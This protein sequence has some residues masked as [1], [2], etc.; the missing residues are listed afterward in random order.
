MMSAQSILMAAAVVL[1]AVSGLRAHDEDLRSGQLKITVG[2]ISDDVALARLKT[3]GVQ[4]PT[5]VRRDDD[6]LVLR[7][8]VEGRTAEIEV[9]VMSGHAV[10]LGADRRS[11]IGPQGTLERPLITGRE[12]PVDHH[13]I[14]RPELMRNAVRPDQEQ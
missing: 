9:D 10:D 5:V 1:L 8:E 2:K 14:A 11:L 6:K 7:G 13:D 4:N 3:A 12:L